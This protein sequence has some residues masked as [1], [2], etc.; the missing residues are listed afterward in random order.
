MPLLYTESD[1]AALLGIPEEEL[2]DYRKN[3]PSLVPNYIL[4]SLTSKILYP[5]SELQKWIEK[6]ELVYTSPIEVRNTATTYPC[7]KCGAN[8][9]LSII[10]TPRTPLITGVCKKCITNLTF[11]FSET[12]VVISPEGRDA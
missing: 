1:L 10:G 8:L 6:Q 2:A 4:S 5:E 3:E 11:K 12:G 9:R 7:P